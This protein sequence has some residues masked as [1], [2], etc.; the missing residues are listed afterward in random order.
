[1]SFAGEHPRGGDDGTGAADSGDECDGLEDSDEDCVAYFEV[2]DLSHAEE[3]SVGD[4]EQDS[5]GEVSD[6]DDDEDISGMC[7]DEFVEE[8]SC[9]E[10]WDG[11][12]CEDDEEFCAWG[13]FFLFDSFEGIAG[14]AEEVARAVCE[15]GEEGSGVCGDFECE[16]V[17]GLDLLTVLVEV[18]VDELQVSA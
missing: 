9:E 18:G 14:D 4:G 16:E 7:C 17:D 3:E 6:G 10:E 13:W 1:M 8:P 12:G 11:C 5:E 15:D 2:L